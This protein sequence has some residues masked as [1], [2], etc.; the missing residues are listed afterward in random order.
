MCVRGEREIVCVYEIDRE[1][2]RKRAKL[3]PLSV[4]IGMTSWTHSI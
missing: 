1:R 2:N 3:A 4:N